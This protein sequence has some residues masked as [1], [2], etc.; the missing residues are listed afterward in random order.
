MTL[1][2]KLQKQLEIRR[3]NLLCGFHTSE[4]KGSG[5]PQTG[6]NSSGEPENQE[7]PVSARTATDPGERIRSARVM[8]GEA[9]VKSG[10]AILTQLNRI[11]S[12]QGGNS[13]SHNSRGRLDSRIGGEIRATPAGSFLYRTELYEESG[14]QLNEEV[15]KNRHKL[16]RALVQL[17][18][19]KPIECEPSQVVFLDTE[20][21][22]LS[23]GAGT[24]AFL[25]GIGSWC[26][27][28]FLVEQF[29]MRDFDE[30]GAMI[31][32]LE[33]RLGQVEVVIT[34]NGKCFDLPLLESRFVMHRR[35]WPLSHRLHLDLLHPSRRLWK[36]RLKDCSLGNLERN[37][38]GLERKGDVPGHLIPQFYFDYARSGVSTALQAIFRHNRQDVR[39]LAELTLIVA[40]ILVGYSS[41]EDLAVQDLYGAAK[42]LAALGQRQQSLQFGE[43]ALGRPG[44]EFLKLEVLRQLANLYSVQRTYSRAASLWEEMMAASQSFEAEACEKLAIHHEHRTGDLERALGLVEDAIQRIES[45]RESQTLGPS[46]KLDRWVHR[47]ARLQRKISRASSV[48]T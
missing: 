40:R 14:I 43:E 6:F 16:V 42:Y 34:F 12:L 38:L 9:N 41:I 19:G 17:L 31:Y 25:V 32:F 33:E 30:E 10:Q 27:S 39:T 29:F 44:S 2:E 26:P 11:R 28:G 7:S 48:Q 5:L 47:R 1:M 35:H 18:T 36:L 24:Y 3:K 20:T 13:R 23:G 46:G 45:K 15:A 4:A 8:S 22:G 37:V 21:T